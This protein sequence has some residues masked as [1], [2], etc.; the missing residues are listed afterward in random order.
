[1]AS[2]DDY[3]IEGKVV[4][5]TGANRGIGKALVEVF[6]KEGAT[7]VYAAVRSLETAQPLVDADSRVH[8]ILMDL[9]KPETIAAAAK[10]TQDVNIVINNASVLSNT[11]PL[12]PDAIS[13]L[14]KEVQVNVYGLMHVAQQFAPALQNGGVFVQINSVASLRCVLPFVSTYSATKAAAFSMTQALRKTLEAQGTNV[15]SVHPGPIATDM[16]QQVGGE[17]AKQAASVEHC[18]QEIVL[19]LKRGDFLCFPDPKSKQLSQAYANF[20][21]HVFEDGNMY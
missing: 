12:S 4:L 7:K 19:A 14:E 16:I 8:P 18:A 17:I 10:E 21:K 15:M 20:A 5:I 3:N 6:L 1:M 2:K 9:A 11:E 13:T